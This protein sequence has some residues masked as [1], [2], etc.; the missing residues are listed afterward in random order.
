MRR[1]PPPPER[2]VKTAKLA[3]QGGYG[4]VE[5]WHDVLLDRD[6]AIKWLTSAAG[7]ET[8][9]NE[10]KFL[11]NAASPFVAE[12][13]DLVFDKD[14]T[15]CGIVLEY[16]DGPDLSA[17]PTP[18]TEE[19]VIGALRVLYQYAR[20]LADLHLMKV[21]HRDVKPENGVLGS[22]GRLKIVD[23]GLSAGGTMDTLRARST[24]GYAAPELFRTAP[25]RV[26]T[27]ADV[28]SFG[29]TAWKVL[30][31]TIPT[32]GP[33]GIPDY[34]AHPLP[35]I[36]T[37]LTLSPQVVS[38]IDGCLIFGE[39]RRLEMEAVSEMFRAELVKGRHQ[40]VVLLSGQPYAINSTSPQ[41]GV[42]GGHGKIGIR[43]DDYRFVLNR[44]EGEVFIN[45]KEAHVGDLLTE[46]CI[47]A[48]GNQARGS[49]RAFAPFRQSSP[50][51][52]I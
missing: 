17:F 28:Y 48:F 29:L 33:V 44:I 41:R 13:Y 2:Y 21:I 25:V 42:D 30:T 49:A 35:S 26:T 45:N 24:F 5:V 40:G 51:V 47:I 39:S 3:K 11:A 9:L 27:A 14:G 16:I 18:T 36:A 12:I 37:R 19:E 43:Y 50:Q 6:V 46:G 22:D 52:V 38:A 31:G 20:G 1:M 8:L 7:E 4:L 10:W 15:L 32:L 23:F 34:S